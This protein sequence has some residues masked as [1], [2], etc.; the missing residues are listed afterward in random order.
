MD[1]RR[2]NKILACGLIAACMGVAGVVGLTSLNSSFV[3]AFYNRNNNEYTLSLNSSN[4]VSTAGDH[5]IRTAAGGSVVFTY[6]SVG[7]YAG[8]HTRIN[9]GGTIVNKSQITSIESFTAT[10]SGGTL[11]ARIAYATDAW[12]EYFSLN[13]GTRIEFGSLPYYLELKADGANINL[14]SAVFTYSCQENPDAT[15]QESGGTYD[16]TFEASG[17]DGTAGLD[18]DGIFELVTSGENL[19]DSF[20]TNGKIFSGKDG[21]KFG[22]SKSY[23]SLTID[24]D[25]T[26][27]SEKISAITLSTAQ[28]SSDTGEFELYLNGSYDC[29]ST[30]IDPSEGGTVAL[31]ADTTLTSLTIETST[32]RGYLIGISLVYGGE[33][34]PNIPD[35][36]D[37]YEVGFTATD[38]NSSVYTTNSIFDRDNALVVRSQKS[39]GTS[40]AVNPRSF[41]YVVKDSNDQA[42]NT[43]NKFP[44]EGTY[45]LVVSY[46][47]YIPIEITL[48]VGEYIYAVD[49]TGSM[50][51]TTFN[52]ADVLSE[53][54]ANNLTASITYSNSSVVSSIAYAE[55]ST[56][57]LGVKLLSKNIVHELENPFGVPGA[58]VLRVYHTSDEANIYYDIQLTVNAVLVETI[59]LD[60][61]TYEL[62]PEG[63]L[64]LVATVNPNTATNSSVEWTTSN[65][66]AATVS[67][68]GLVTAVAVGSATITATAVDGSG[69]YGSCVITVTAAPSTSE[70]DAELGLGTNASDCT[71]NDI[72]GVKVGTSKNSGN[73]TVTV[74]AGAVRL[75]FYAAAWNGSGSPTLSMSGATAGT[76]SFTLTSD[77]GVANNSPFTLSGDV[78]DYFFETTLSNVTQETTLTFS[79]AKRFVL[80]N[81]KYYT[82]SAAPADPVYP[83][84]ISLSGTSSIAI[85]ETSQLSVDY[86][87]ST[88]NVKNVTFSSSNS[89]IAGVSNT[90]LVT[91]VAAGTAT[92]TATAQAQSGT[93]TTTKTITVNPV[94]VTSVSLSETSATL[95]VGKTLTLIATVLP[96]NAT[97]K[98]VTWSTG[99]S[100]IA[101]VSNSGVVTGV[102]AGTTNITVTT[103]DGSKTAR[104]SVTVVASSGEEEFSISYTDLPTAYQTGSTVY[105]AASGV[106]FQAYNCANYSSK[107]QFKASS[108]YLQNTESLELQSITIND[109]ESNSL[110][111]YGSNTAGSFSNEISGSNDVYNLTGYNYFKIARTTTGAAYCSS[112]TILTGTPTPTDPTNIT[113]DPTS[114]E[115]APG[116]TKN[117][118]VTYTP[119]NAN[120][121]KEIT[122][123]SS[124]TNV[125]TVDSSGKVSVKSTATVGQSA[126]ITAKLTNIPSISKTC[127]V[128]VVEQKL[129][130]HTVLIY[131]CGADL[132]SGSGLATGD[133]REILSVSNQ[134][135]DVNIVIETGGASSWRSTYGISSSKLERWHVENKSLV[136]DDSLATYSSMGLSSTL[137]SFVEYGL[138][139][140]PAERTGLIFWNH[141]GAMR[142]CCYDEKKNDDSLLTD[143]V[144]NALSGAF[145]N[146]GKSGQKL[147]WVGYDCCL[148]QVQDIASINSDYF[149]YMIAS[150]ESEAGYGWDYDTWVDDLYAHKT[151]PVILKAIVDGFIADNGG[152]SSSSNDQTLSYL[153]LG[154][155]SA[156][157]TAWN[158]MATQ[159]GTKLNSSN[160]SN[161]NT[162]VKSCK[163]Y[164]D[165]DY[166]YYGIFDAK[167]FINKLAANST[168]NPGSSYTNA[169]LTAFNNLV[170]YSSCGRAAGNS[171]GV[172]MFWSVS[173]NCQKGTYYTA[174]M[175]KF[176]SWRSLV[177]T[178]GY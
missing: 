117:I 56:H 44:T 58:W 152:T 119:N 43:A 18:N 50:T 70:F 74:G 20:S 69:V 15:P 131:L 110:T 26:E 173:S 149:N 138:N 61:S 126:T 63:T 135:D 49:V 13:S 105:T 142:G 11:K 35:S 76:S 42:I 2:K 123:T 166:T 6:T 62:H 25:T 45:T 38:A 101:T 163:Y 90:G 33:S 170:A 125:A 103:A 36:P 8:G 46:S 17:S 108:G 55:F 67:D 9:N 178:Y 22:S 147:E 127:T 106:K 132:E 41:S 83:T 1:T 57:G 161:F 153:N 32:K 88:T 12:G 78:E 31:A 148:M 177:V 53:H 77:S 133:L 141:G 72:D 3:E 104:C 107:M 143:E 158:N 79:C 150:E 169:V 175:T 113:L 80:W 144:S 85:G 7:S 60:H 4:A 64:Q 39:N 114:C 156:Y 94:S 159:L 171:Y 168:F 124:N 167:D 165:S 109:R 40:T 19:V 28:Y 111:V 146:C 98:N 66:E 154:Y 81:A 112:I 174:S 99:S 27:V 120:Q 24:F 118:A 59:T 48:N 122:W 176:N 86:T 71:V 145:S 68:S 82:Q 93:V 115:L 52:T 139:N 96:N 21:L 65:D 30:K 51:T 140:Y 84:A 134:P 151:T 157:I 73:M 97:N 160:K 164:A 129:D 5:T 100:A 116:G 137:Q 102:G 87:P 37:V 23:G 128:T 75:T 89:N 136:K 47:Q 92:I 10:F 95:R 162:L 155:M 130:D 172:C 14:T 29:L 34:G 91:G 16:I 54:L 121:N